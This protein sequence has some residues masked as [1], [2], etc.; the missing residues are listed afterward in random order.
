MGTVSGVRYSNGE[1]SQ[2]GELV[3]WQSAFEE[4]G[5]IPILKK[6]HV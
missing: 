2:M 3:C 1:F 6:C 4:I 5:K